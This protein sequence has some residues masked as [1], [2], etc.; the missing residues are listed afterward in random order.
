MIEGKPTGDLLKN[1]INQ[2]LTDVGL[3][4][5][6]AEKYIHEFSG[7][8]RQRITIARALII[9]PSLI[10]LDE[11]VSA[12]DVSIRAQVLDL[13]AEL[14]NKFDLSYLFISHDMKVIRSVADKIIVLQ[15]GKI[16][17][18]NTAKNLFESPKNPYTKNLI[19]GI[20]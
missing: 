20:I 9:K 6:D 2:A 15:K 1:A 14:S 17:E 3:N 8:Q 4:A 11:A 13:L 18:Q 16:V 10:V 12:L 5:Q 19:S 7:G